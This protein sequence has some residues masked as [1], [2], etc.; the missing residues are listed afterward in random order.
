MKTGLILDKTH[1]P[2]ENISNR[3]SIAIIR[4]PQNSIASNLSMGHYYNL[5]GE[6]LDLE[7]SSQASVYTELYKKMLK[8][9]DIVFTYDYLISNP[10]KVVE[11]ISKIADINI[12]EAVRDPSVLDIGVTQYL[13]TSKS[14]E[15]YQKIYN[16]IVSTDLSEAD[17]IYKAVLESDLVFNQ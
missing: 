2:L 11:K 8:E 15:G 6:D 12:N 13:P 10:D 1:S 3:V 16:R 4:N 9:V 17:K 5:I 7:I 14:H